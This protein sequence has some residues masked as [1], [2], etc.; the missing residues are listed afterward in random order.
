MLEKLNYIFRRKEK[1]KILGILV[2]IIIGSFFELMG[3]AIF[4]P[5]IQIIM[6]PDMVYTVMAV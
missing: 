2:L 1:I 5:F 4:M 3:V 6:E